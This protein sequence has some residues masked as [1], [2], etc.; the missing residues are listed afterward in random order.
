MYG[1]VVSWEGRLGVKVERGWWM[2]GDQRI[3]GRCSWGGLRTGPGFGEEK[4][5]F[6]PGLFHLFWNQTDMRQSNW[7]KHPEFYYLHREAQSGNWDPKKWPKQAEMEIHFLVI[8]SN[9][10]LI[11]LCFREESPE[12]SYISIPFTLPAAFFCFWERRR[13]HVCVSQAG[14]EWEGE[15]ENTKQA[16]QH[17]H[18]A[19][20]RAWTHKLWDHDLSWNQQSVAQPNEP[21]RHTLP[22]PAKPY[23]HI[24]SH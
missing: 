17:H 15:R 11:Q 8:S 6:S 21:S 13:L 24:N 20:C 12:S 7:K 10:T 22:P 19:Q 23:L 16:L 2:I 18:R 4:F 9:Q 3:R 14:S 1:P 5:P